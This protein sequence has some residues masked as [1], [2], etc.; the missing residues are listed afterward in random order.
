MTSYDHISDFENT[1][2]DW[3]K[4]MFLKERMLFKEMM[5][6]ILDPIRRGAASPEGDS[7][8]PVLILMARLVNDYEATMRLILMGLGEQ[9]YQSMRDSV[10]TSLLLLLFQLDEKLATRWMIDLKQYMTGTVIAE[11]KKHDADYPLSEMYS[12]LSVLSHPNFI[13]SM[14]VVEEIQVGEDRLLRTYHFGG[15]RNAGFMKL[16]LMSLMTLMMMAMFSA[17]PVPFAVNDPEFLTW[18]E[19]AQKWPQRLQDDLSLDF[20]ATAAPSG[21]EIVRKIELRL[22]VDLF[23]REAVREASREGEGDPPNFDQ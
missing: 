13:S 23:N 18:W 16:Q 15:Y 10:E 8:A 4:G 14:H 1:L 11:L 22:K 5:N 9:A 6:D 2:T 3:S 7:K 21:Q 19:K 20:E 17:L 12:T